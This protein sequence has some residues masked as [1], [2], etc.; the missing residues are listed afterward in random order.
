VRRI[1]RQHGGRTITA[2][3]RRQARDQIFCQGQPRLGVSAD[4]LLAE[5]G[6]IY[7]KGNTSKGMTWKDAAS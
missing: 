6:R 7:V 4:M 2:I 1:R 5:G 3:R